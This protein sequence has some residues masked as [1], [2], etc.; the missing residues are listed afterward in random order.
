[1]EEYEGS[2]FE[3]TV[4]DTLDELIENG[5]HPIDILYELNADKYIAVIVYV[6]E[7][8]LY[9]EVITDD[10]LQGDDNEITRTEGHEGEE[11]RRD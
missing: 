1:M 2:I 9:R 11:E 10:K 7:D 5:F 6:N 8:K 3:D 4:N